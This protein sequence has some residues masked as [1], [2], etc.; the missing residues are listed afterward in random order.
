VTLRSRLSFE[1]VATSWVPE[2]RHHLQGCSFVLVGTKS[3]LRDDAAFVAKMAKE[4]RVVVAQ[5][6]AAELAKS[7][8]AAAYVETSAKLRRGLDDAFTAAVREGARRRHATGATGTR[9]T[10][11]CSIL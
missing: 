6:D 8:G 11:R 10:R 3:D 7:L 2:I 4:G 5:S 9:R 1:H